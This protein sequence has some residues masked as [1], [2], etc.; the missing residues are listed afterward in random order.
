MPRESGTTGF[1]PSLAQLVSRLRRKPYIRLQLR[2]EAIPRTGVAIHG[3]PSA[4][5]KDKEGLD[6]EWHS[7]IWRGLNDFTA[8]W[9][10]FR[11][12]MLDSALLAQSTLG[13]QGKGR[14]ACARPTD[15]P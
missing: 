15:S 7:H 3:T 13:R 8:M 5:K 12:A 4:K 2:Q 10:P 14:P 9:I 11:S 1:T 6:D